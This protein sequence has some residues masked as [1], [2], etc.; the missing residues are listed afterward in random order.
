MSDQIDGKVK[1]QRVDRM[2]R[3][4]EKIAE[5]FFLRNTGTIRRVLFER[6]DPQ[7]SMLAGLTDNYIHTYCRMEKDEAERYVNR[8]ADVQLGELYQDGLTGILAEKTEQ[9]ADQAPE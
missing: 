9:R 8:F 1:A 7:T 5:N 2:I 6:Y 3:L 4:S